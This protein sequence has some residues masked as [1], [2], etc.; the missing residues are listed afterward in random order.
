MAEDV[1]IGLINNAAL[2]LAMGLIYDIL[3]KRKHSAGNFLYQTVSGIVVG[4]IA[5]VIMSTPVKWEP[6]VIF[7]TR[8]ILF[9]LTGLFFGTIPTT[10]AM[11]IAAA[12]RMHL[13]GSG[14]VAGVASIVTASLIGM[15]WRKFRGKRLQELTLVEL[16]VLGMI[17]HAGMILCMLLLPQEP[18][19]RFFRT[20]AIPVIVI[21]PIATAL[22]GGLLCSRQKRHDAEENVRLLLDST[23]EGIYGIDLEGNCSFCNSACLK[24]LGYTSQDELLGKDMHRL[25]HH[26]YQDGTPF[27]VEEC[28]I[29]KAFRSGEG[30]HVDD[31]VFWRADG[32]NFIAEYW[33]YPQIR[34][35]QIVGA[36]VTFLN[37]TE[38][39]EAEETLKKNQNMLQEIF[40]AIPQH[41]FWKDRESRYLGC[42]RLFAEATGM[43]RPED[44]VGKTDYDLPWPSDEAEA[45]RAY[46]RFVMENNQPKR[47]IIEPLLQA[48][49]NRIWI[50][51][52]KVP[53]TDGEGSVYGML[54]VYEDITERMQSEEILRESNERFSTA[55]NHA[56][57][58]MTISNMED[59][60]YLDVNQVF[61]E[62]SGFS[63]EE[64]IGRTSI[65]LGWITE[66]D[67][68]TLKEKLLKDGNVRDMDLILHA[69]SGRPVLCK[70][71]GEIINSGG[72]RQLLSIA[73]DV[74]EHRSVEQQLVQAQKMESVGRLAGG[75]AHD[76]NNM[77]SV[78][79]GHAELGL[80]DGSLADP[81]RKHLEAIFDAANRSSAVTRQLLAFAR[82]Q[83]VEPRVLD[84]N[85]T[86]SGMLKMLNRLIG[87]DIEL[88]WIPGHDLNRVKIDP[89][90]VDQLLANVCV[91]AR[92]AIS[93]VGRI[94][95]HTENVTVGASMTGTMSDV[96]PGEY[97]LLTVDDS[98]QGMTSD[99]LSH[100]FEPFYTTKE[101]GKGTGL[102]LA[103]VY[104]IVKQ[105][106]GG[107]TVESEPGSGATFRIYLPVVAV[108]QPD[109]QGCGESAVNS[110][111]ESILLVEDEPSVMAMVADMLTSL[112]YRVIM[113]STP[114]EA[115]LAA[116]RERDTLSLLLSDV[117]MPGMNGSDLAKHLQQMN[118]KLKCLFMSGY[119]S[120]VIADH[121]AIKEAVHFISKPFSLHDIARKV[122]EV[123]DT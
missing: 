56:P 6:G 42:N 113:A 44:I 109:K 58:M 105:N 96:P 35:G 12:Y 85:D 5:V 82:R 119:T 28:L 61:L 95:I 25:I 97:V 81:Q 34:D 63:R 59:G 76:F 22:L 1:L 111:N 48:D 11:A 112:G 68:A 74:T 3:Y 84:L 83:T 15:L 80:L 45:Y 65:D 60:V 69:K 8:T 24:M 70:Y 55:F 71:W 120:D 77:L 31:E 73:L 102:G 92:D 16:Y 57:V 53:L 88:R 51:T 26:S 103:T 93:G 41:V 104:G 54:G 7:D 62:V 79:L 36:V 20:L 99:V 75:V 110:G 47:H 46:D 64:V 117:I 115:I 108:A 9:G 86:V 27:P 39:R 14:M 18:M 2:L 91:N 19:N 29:F 100:I 43:K 114:E 17:V 40:N 23:A 37:I 38:R 90:Q 67:R 66:A 118:P 32:T 78:I 10:M 121:G 13:G 72:Q 123:L 49:G 52:T 101:Q 33:S 30:A 89:A 50:D 106:Q 94:S 21:Y 116:G 98:G 122:R 107:I 4:I 87:E